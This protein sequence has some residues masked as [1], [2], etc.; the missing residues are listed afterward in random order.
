MVQLDTLLASRASERLKEQI[1]YRDRAKISK[2]SFIRT[3]R[4]SQGNIEACVYTII[5]LQYLG[6]LAPDVLEGLARTGRLM[7][8]LRESS[9]SNDE[10]RRFL[11]SLEEYAHI[12]SGRRKPHL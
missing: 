3:L 7:S 8:K 6:A 5:L 9:P 4:Q 12:V 2:G 1:S 11:Q 10:I